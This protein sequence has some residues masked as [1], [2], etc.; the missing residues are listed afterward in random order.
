[1]YQDIFG[2]EVAVDDR[3]GV[4]IVESIDD[5]LEKGQGIEG[6]ESTTVDKEIEKL[7]TFDVF[8]DQIK[9]VFALEDIVYAEY[10]GV[11]H[12]FHHDDFPVD[13][14]TLFLGFGEVGSQ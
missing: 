4:R 12:E 8:E 11:V 7:A 5:L 14:K 6:R 3:K 10:V 9:F 13:S 1:M 2:L